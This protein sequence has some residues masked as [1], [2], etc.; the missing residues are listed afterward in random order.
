M[1]SIYCILYWLKYFLVENE[2]SGYKGVKGNDNDN[3]FIKH[4]YSLQ[5][6]IY[7]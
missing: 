2:I 4:K 1:Y 3:T 7:I 6:R 5:V